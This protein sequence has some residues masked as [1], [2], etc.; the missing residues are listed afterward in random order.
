MSRDITNSKREELPSDATRQQ[1]PEL[2][3]EALVKIEAKKQPLSVS[4]PI[5]ILELS[6]AGANWIR[7]NENAD[8]Y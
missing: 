7:K 3:V 8:S 1:N 5:D 4:E 2:Y 6:P